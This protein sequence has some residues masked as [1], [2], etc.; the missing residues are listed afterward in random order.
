MIAP[1]SRRLT[2]TAAALAAVTLAAVTACGSGGSS[3]AERRAATVLLDWEPNP[4]HL[5]LYS[6]Q[7][8]GDYAAAGLNVTLR[9]PSDPSDPLKLVS[10]GTV[11]LGIS[12]EPEVVIAGVEKLDVVAVGALIPTALNSIM[13][14][15]SA[16]ITKPADLAGATVGTS[17][18]R[19][20]EA[21]LDA[22]AKANHF[23][24][25]SI[26]RV[27]VGADLLPAMISKK[28]TATL[29]AYRNVEGVTLADR[30]LAPKVIPVTEAG[31]P[32]YDEL[33]IVARRSRL[34]KDP[35][36]AALVRDFLR[37]TAAGNARAL[38]DPAKATTTLTGVAD[39][40]DPKLLPKMVEATAPLLRNP[41]GFGRMDTGAWTSFIAWMRAEDLIK[42]TV[43]T[44][45]VV[46]NAYL[47][48]P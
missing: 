42:A 31:V 4:D 32:Q 30:G 18:L 37:A 22:I 43:P 39:G 33:V 11:D 5:A 36:Y 8:G 34:A 25:T 24:G 41:A 27:D 16:G 10:T 40:Y 35:A 1:R 17:G 47:P 12:Y 14:V 3:G 20:D 45:D 23:D 9:S 29:G 46:T 19:T 21:F 7:D 15:G 6:A 48:K 13:A 2:I 26:H 28:V 38:D 44:A